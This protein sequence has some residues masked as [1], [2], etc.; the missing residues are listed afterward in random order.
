MK[1]HSRWLLAGSILG[2]ALVGSSARAPH[3]AAC[4]Q[5]L[6]LFAGEPVDGATDVP[7]D[8][9]PWGQSTGVDL[10]TVTLTVAGGADPDLTATVGPLFDSLSGS[11][12]PF[13][14]TYFAV[15]LSAELRPN[16]AYQIDWASDHEQ[17]TLMTFTTGA[18]PL[19]EAVPPPPTLTAQMFRTSGPET[20]SCGPAD[21]VCIGGGT[22][23]LQAIFRDQITEGV[24]SVGMAPDGSFASTFSRLLTE[25]DWCAEV[26]AR[27][28]AGHYSDAVTVCS[29]D[30]DVFATN[31]ASDQVSV[32][33]DHGRLVDAE[34]F[35]DERAPQPFDPDSGGGCSVSPSR[36]GPMWAG[37]FG[38]AVALS[39]VRRRR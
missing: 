3:A 20:S 27:D 29:T 39:L 26:R 37:L 24:L 2:L 23:G 10:S 12:I 31:G 18:G 5:A 21:T 7:T 35:L 38:L 9:I 16:T 33:C 17:G 22:A 1:R 30:E 14:D 6:M 25:N 8:V 4:S 28:L 13:A 19:G 36:R 32:S 11:A 34:G 15:H